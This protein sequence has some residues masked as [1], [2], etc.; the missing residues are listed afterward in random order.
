MLYPRLGGL[1]RLVRLEKLLIYTLLLTLFVG[2]IVVAVSFN[3]FGGSPSGIIRSLALFYLENMYNVYAKTFWAASPEAVNAI[4]WDYR[5]LDTIYETTVL[6][7]ALIGCLA[8]AT[9]L[10]K[11]FRP[12]EPGL[13]I[14]VK[15]GTR[16]VVAIVILVSLVLAFRGYITPGG[17]FQGGVAFAI[18]PLLLIAAYSWR[19]LEELGFRLDKAVLLRSLGLAAIA[20]IALAP[21]MLGGYILQNQFK[22]WIVFAGAPYTIWVFYIGGTLLFLNISEFFVVSMEFLTIFILLSIIYVGGEK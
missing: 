18:A 17:G 10:E 4:L 7:T 21:Y 16:I 11:K 8:I 5:G 20:L 13:T 3:V 15:A 6:Y 12:R 9:G 1:R 22:P 14:I 2:G 19:R